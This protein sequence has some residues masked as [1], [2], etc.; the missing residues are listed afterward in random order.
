MKSKK[1]EFCGKVLPADHKTRYCNERCRS[2]QHHLTW[3]L[4]VKKH[5]YPQQKVATPQGSNTNPIK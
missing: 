2:N 5:G 1:C 3:L 4:K